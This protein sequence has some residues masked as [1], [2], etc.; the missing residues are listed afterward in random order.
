MSYINTVDDVMNRVPAI[1]S[2]KALKKV[3]NV[4]GVKFIP[5][6]NSDQPKYKVIRKKQ[7]NQGRVQ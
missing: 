3:S 4:Y 5:A 6:D 2:Q 1:L 7:N